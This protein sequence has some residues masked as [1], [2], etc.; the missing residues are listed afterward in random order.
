VGVLVDMVEGKLQFTINGKL[1][2][3]EYKDS[4]LKSHK[5]IPTVALEEMNTS[6][7]LSNM[8]LRL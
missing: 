8:L 3:F 5:V 6:V 7:H 1:Y 4:L 2:G